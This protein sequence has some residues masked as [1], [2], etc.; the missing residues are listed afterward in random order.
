[1]SKAVVAKSKLYQ[2]MAKR[3][4]IKENRDDVLVDKWAR[5]RPGIRLEKL[6][7]ENRSKARQVA[8]SLEMENRHIKKL[9]EDGTQIK[10]L[11]RTTPE[12]LL[13]IIRI[14]VANSN[15]SEIFN[16]WSLETPDDAFYF[17]DSIYGSTKRGAT[18]GGLI[19]ETTAE[20]YASEFNKLSLGTG[21][22][23]N[24]TFGPGSFSPTPLIPNSFRIIVGGR[25]VGNDDG[26]SSF[27]GAT[28]DATSSID[29]TT[30]A[31]TVVFT[32]GNA[33]ANGATV[34]VEGQ[35]DSEK[36]TN[37][38]EWGSVELALRKGR[39]NARIMPLFY[40]YSQLL[41]ITL[42]STG[43]GNV[44]DM[45]VKRVGD[46]HAKRKDQRAFHVAMQEARKN[47]LETFDCDF[48]TA[49]SDN[50]YNHNQ[51][52]ITTL[53]KI[54]GK[55]YDEKQRGRITKIV[56]GSQ[57]LA[58]AK[59]I[60][61]WEKDTTQPRGS[62]SYLAGRI[63][64]IDVYSTPA[65]TNTVAADEA[66]L[67]YRNADEDGDIAIA[68]GVMTELAADLNYPEL[69]KKGSVA[70]VEDFKVIESGFLRLL[71]FE[72]V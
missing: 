28:I 64:D 70:T 29:Y 21:N 1:M 20:D 27:T 40:S 25:A 6:Y 46:E 8:R 39:F 26:V 35:W 3:Y 57:A 66:L 55:I 44:D 48:A 52:I 12:N 24:V 11:F 32:A 7:A 60:K 54:S 15:R 14:G 41:E 43:I 45:L 16:E 2:E 71:K 62:G 58:E 37:Y 69:Y 33:P 50:K 5:T 38:G 13:R 61:G 19:Y 65:N 4:S 22:G 49:G 10:S 72:N 18:A 68:F 23:S 36:S 47:A 9:R 51:T 34:I 17:V 63:D 31:I 67:V 53:E 56:M 42:G 59:I 30:G